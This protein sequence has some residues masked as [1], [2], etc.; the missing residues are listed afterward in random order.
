MRLRIVAFF[1]LV[2]AAHTLRAQTVLF[3]EDF[4]DCALPSGWQVSSVGNQNP[5]WL[6]GYSTNNDALGQSIDSTCC[7]I[8]DDDATGDNT[9]PYVIS[10]TSPAFDASQFS[11]IE[12]TMDV[13][14]RD[15]APSQEY[16]EVLVTD[17][18]TEHRIARY[19]E[20]RRNGALLSDHFTLK[21]DLSLITHSPQTRI[22]LRYDDAA[23]FAWWAAVDN[24]LIR[25]YGNGTNVVAETF[26]DCQKPAGWETEIVAGDA[27][28]QFGLVDT[29]SKGY[30]NGNS[31]D[32]TCFALFDDDLVG[33]DAPYSTVRLA[34]PW[35]DGSEYASYE[36]NF[37]VILR[38][39][40][41]RI[42][43]I[44]QHANGDEFVIRESDG[45]VG[46]PYFPQY[47]HAGL[48][49]SPYRNQQ[50]RVIFEYV[51]GNAWGWWVGID[52][53][54]ITGSGEANDLCTNATEITTGATCVL[55][56]N[57]TALFDGPPAPCTPKSIA[58]VWFKWQATFSGQA[59]LTTQTDFN[60]VTSIF[61]GNCIN[62]QLLLCN[63]HDEHGFTGETTF[64]TAQAGTTYLFRVSGQEGGFG[65]PRGHLCIRV[66]QVS[67]LPVVPANDQCSGAIVLTENTN[68]VTINNVNAQTAQPLVSLD[69]LARADVWY[70]FTAPA[71]AANER[72]EIRSN[73]DFSD[74]ISV[75]KGSCGALEEVAGTHKG[76]LL[77]LPILT[78]GDNYLVQ[79]AGNFATIEGHLCPQ[80]LRKQVQAPANDDCVSAVSVSIGSQ[81]T[82]SANLNATFSG[83]QPSCVVQAD[84]DVWFKFTAPSSGTVRINTGATFEH[85]L[86][87]W[88]GNCDNLHEVFCAKNPLR[89]NGFVTIGS[90]SSGQTYY[91][92]I[93]SWN[94][95]AGLNSGDICLKIQ[96]GLNPPEFQPMSLTVNENCIGAGLARLHVSVH[97]GVAPYAYQGTPDGQVLNSGDVYLVIVKDAIGCEQSLVG[98]VDECQANDCNV[99]ASVSVQ[100]PS[101][102]AGNDGSLAANVVGGVEPYTYQWSNSATTANV[103][104]LTAGVYT[105][106]VTDAVDCET[107]LTQTLTEPLPLSV[108]PTSILQP[109]QGQSNGAVLVD[110]FGGNGNYLYNWLL[111]GAPFA[112]S[113]DLT[114]APAGEYQLQVTDGSG[115]TGVFD[116]TLTETV[117]TSQP[118]E[119]VFAEVFPNPAREKAT[120][121]VAFPAT[122]SLFWSIVD[123]NGRILK[124]KAAGS[125]MEQN[126]SLEIK[127]LPAGSYQVRILT[128]HE[129]LMQ[130]LVVV[131]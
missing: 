34:T 6:V 96:N 128:E 52:N 51:D 69:T 48:D 4:N 5:V 44:V 46:G 125:V 25:G 90:L 12:L 116:I 79:I 29:A 49:L 74:V 2:L 41:E 28:W 129:L 94:G 30:S 130:P 77:E 63:N 95:A 42:A 31:M 9:A 127:D 45:D 61:T 60:D 85:V 14:Y 26:N 3:S 56:D 68:C 92:Q 18:V 104:G 7:L 81:C 66:E 102:F 83:K 123:A 100:N 23:G 27:D 64:F 88:Q 89:C 108:A 20:H 36:L 58:S 101:C 72:L 76:G 99:I 17:G 75:Y 10:F 71:L 65:V 84:R 131:K 16:F 38:Y 54:K 80:I 33:Q 110:I 86:T 62:P 40:K 1:L 39:V 37:D 32:G 115:C 105:V 91:V 47:L 13:H 35:F 11:T 82:A 93:A 70:T 22:I 124:S 106:T 126:I 114:N 112:Q 55:D 121:A 24:I 118:D 59:R 117:G 21:Y 50:M 119:Q 73:A 19:D 97:D 111:N 120:L 122:R 87:L 57:L 15:W 67:S 53:V 113:E 8:I 107:V 78:A 109:S 98:I 43:V 103:S